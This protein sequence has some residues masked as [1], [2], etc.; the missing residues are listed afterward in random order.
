M[1]IAH[2]DVGAILE[3]YVYASSAEAF[4]GLDG[5]KQVPRE[6]GVRWVP[7]RDE[8]G[9]WRIQ[10]AW[11]HGVAVKGDGTVGQRGRWARYSGTSITLMPKWLA[12]IAQAGPVLAYAAVRE[13]HGVELSAR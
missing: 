7:S 12:Q 11:V 3:G 10:S 8:A 5:L 9:G 1:K 13:L 6:F 2:K 4:S